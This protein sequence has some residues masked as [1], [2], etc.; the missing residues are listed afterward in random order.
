M[1]HHSMFAAL[2][3]ILDPQY[4]MSFEVKAVMP[5]AS[6]G[7]MQ[8][9]EMDDLTA[10]DTTWILQHVEGTLPDG[11]DDALFEVSAGGEALLGYIVCY[12]SADGDLMRAYSYCLAGG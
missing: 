11:G 1:R 6:G 10:D 2:S 12:Y 7:M 9:P 5:D 3:H 4:C 8:Y